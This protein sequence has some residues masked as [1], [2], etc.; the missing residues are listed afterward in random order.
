MRE[1]VLD[2]ETT[3]LDPDRGHRV[4]EIGCVEL[5]NYVPTG[6]VRHYYLNPERD[7]P[8]DVVRVHGLTGEFLADKPLFSSIA[9]DFVAF[10]GDA[11]LVIHNAAFDLKFVNAELKRLGIPMIPFERTIDTVKLARQR[12]PRLR[13]NLDAVCKRFGIDTSHRDKH[14]ALLDAELTA[15]VYLALR[16]GRQLGLMEDDSA[17]GAETISQFAASARPFRAPRVF[18]VSEAEKA[19]HDALV[20]TM[21]GALWRSR[22]AS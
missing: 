12:D 14:G 5:F 4:V 22:K 8:A 10:L 18:T 7:V 16:G 11:P 21:P 15:Q 19:A 20:E 17:A 3:G 2:T 1:I 13:A 6:D 9:A